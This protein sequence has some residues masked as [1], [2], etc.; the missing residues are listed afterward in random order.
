MTTGTW[1]R[2]RKPYLG[3]IPT[4]MLAMALVATSP[5][6]TLK[7]YHLATGEDFLFG[8]LRCDEARALG[9]YSG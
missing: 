7:G 5:G 1:R 3:V 2:A 4:L 6:L 9:R 8:V